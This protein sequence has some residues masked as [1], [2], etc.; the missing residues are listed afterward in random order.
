MSD[1]NITPN[2]GISASVLKNIAYIT[3]IIDHIGYG[4]IGRY[5]DSLGYNIMDVPVYILAR[6]I[7]RIAFPIFIFMLVEGY[8]RT[9]NKLNYFIRLFILAVISEIPYNLVADFRIIELSDKNVMFDLSI[10]FLV[11][12]GV[13][14]SCNRFKEKIWLRNLLN[15]VIVL[16]GM[17]L[18]AVLGTDYAVTSVGMTLVF[19]FFCYD[20]KKLWT[21]FCAWI[22]IG[23]FIS[24][25]IM[26]AQLLGFNLFSRGYINIVISGTI[27]EFA[28][29]LAL[30][31]IS[32]Y[33]GKK[34]RQAF[35]YVYYA[36]YPVQ[37]ILIYILSRMLLG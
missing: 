14:Y 11:L 34:G 12:W 25:Y 20:S 24:A 18:E 2:S 6:T 33:N 27:D 22:V 32:F 23:P 8:Y 19:Y 29:I 35:K 37:F 10:S 5:Y 4:I 36:I 30:I 9:K 17:T 26:Y 28:A 31:P 3:M 21:A 15:V 16:S 1:S 7:G 13:D